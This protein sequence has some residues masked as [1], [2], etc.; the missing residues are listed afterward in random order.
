[1]KLYEVVEQNLPLFKALYKDAKG[2]DVFLTRYN[3]Y[4]KFKE[5]EDKG[6]HKTRIAIFRDLK[7][8]SKIGLYTMVNYVNY[9]EKE[10]DYVPK[11]Y[12]FLKQQELIGNIK[13]ML[14]D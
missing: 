2:S 14:N 7:S 6:I 4:K 8:K 3:F 11:E 5:E 10:I 9:M 12:D 13:K 1:M